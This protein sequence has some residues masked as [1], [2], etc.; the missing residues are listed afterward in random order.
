MRR[1]LQPV[2]KRT[3]TQEAFDQLV[4]YLEGDTL[5]P[6]DALPSQ[7]ELA[8]QLGVSRPVLREAMQRLEAAGL[9]EIR[10]GSGSYVARPPA[11]TL[12][13][14]I[15]GQFTHDQAV[16][17]LEARMVIEAECAALAAVRATDEDFEAMQ[18]AVDKIRELA[19]QGELTI[20]GADAF[21]EALTAA[22]H[23]S[24]LTM[25]GKLFKMPNYIQGVRVELALPDISGHESESHYRLLEAIQLRDPDLARARVREHLERS[26]GTTEQAATLK[27][28]FEQSIG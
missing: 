11:E 15:L 25:L 3:L 13:E 10:H 5:R 1:R 4:S 16:D 22:S 28:Q 12:L 17:L 24:V 9:V 8:D 23:N 18:A 20:D 21:H 7:Q 6:G 14:R 26:H 27:K 19:D 2:Q